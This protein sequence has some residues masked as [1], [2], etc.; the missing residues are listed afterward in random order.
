MSN[1]PPVQPVPQ[2]AAAPAKAKT[3]GLA[4]ASLVLGIVGPCTVGLGSIIGLI[5]GIVGLVKIG[6]SAGAKG[7]R[8]LAIAGIAVSGLGIL[9]LPVLAAILLPAVYSAMHLANSASSANN[10][11]QLCIT[12]QIYATAHRQ[13]LPPADSW[14]QVFQEQAGLSADVM[15]DPGDDKGGRAYAMNAGLGGTIQHPDPSRTVLFFE[16]R[17][18]APPAG[19]PD[20][21]PDEPRHAGKYVI[22]FLDG[23]V[24]SVAPEE[25]RRLIWQ[26]GLAPES[27]AMQT[28]ETPESG[29]ARP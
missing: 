10:V 5:L 20:L 26:P 9:I 23:H 15:T 4:I 29:E 25:V 22:G 12:A 14:P 11:K 2:P 13:Q 21:L 19:G 6:K 27:P 17:P 3:S 16:C 18:G 28:P 7:G 24:E 8:G 1:V